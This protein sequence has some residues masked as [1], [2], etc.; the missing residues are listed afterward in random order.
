MLE[1]GYAFRRAAESNQAACLGNES[2]GCERARIG[3][4]ELFEMS[5]RIEELVK[6]LSKAPQQV[7]EKYKALVGDRPPG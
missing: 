5:E 1:P 2:L 6:Q 4:C 7:I 3:R